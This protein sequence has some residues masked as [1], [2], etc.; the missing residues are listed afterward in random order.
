MPL[1]IRR[2]R[3]VASAGAL[4]V[5]LLASATPASADGCPEERLDRPYILYL[6]TGQYFIAEGGH[7]EGPSTSWHRAGGADLL[8]RG[9]INDYGG[10]QVM[11]LPAGASVTSPPVCIDVTRPHMRF[12]VRT[13][14]LLTKLR[15]EAVREDGSRV[16]LATFS[17]LTDFLVWGVSPKVP[18]TGPLGIRGDHH[19]YV[20]LRLQA[21]SGT[22]LVDDVAVDPYKRG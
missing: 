17:S 2:R 7:F 19:E 1:S 11:R 15:V 8:P 14:F 4:L 12:D 13:S 16:H 5:G 21:V 3:I 6:D 9:R 22:W 20:R 18:L 10:E